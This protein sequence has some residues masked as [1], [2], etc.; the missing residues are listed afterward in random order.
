LNTNQE[1]IDRSGSCAVFTLI[2]EDICYIANVGDSRAVMSTHSGKKLATLTNDHKPNDEKETKRIVENGG[3]VYQTQTNAKNLNFPNT[4]TGNNQILLG[5]HRVFPGRLSVSRTFGDVEAKLSKFGG[6]SGVIIAVPDIT[7]FKINSE[8]DFIVLGC[9]GIYDQ[10]NNKEVVDCVWMTMKESPRAKNLHIQ[11]GMAVDMVLKTSLVR[12]TLDNVTAVMI[13][14]PNMETYFNGGNTNISQSY[15]TPNTNIEKNYKSNQT[16]EQKKNLIPSTNPTSN[17]SSNNNNY[18]SNKENS[19][20]VK[21]KLVEELTTKSEKLKS[22]TLYNS[23]FVSKTSNSSHTS[24]RKPTD[25]L[26]E[27]VDI[28]KKTDNTNVHRA[29]YDKGTSNSNSLKK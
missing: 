6:M 4:S 12:R 26:I 24:T 27:S 8:M 16:S 2:I 7:Q 5:P 19:N 10:L 20:Q 21:S 3:K 13:A 15:M 11:C 25:E 22:N 18:H 29:S 17:N 9:D 14:F 28:S 23:A 1:I